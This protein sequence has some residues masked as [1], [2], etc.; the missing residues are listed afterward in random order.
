MKEK[1]SMVRKNVCVCVYQRPKLGWWKISLR[2]FGKDQFEL[3][4]Q[5]KRD[6]N[7]PGNI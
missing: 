1:Q 4:K 7:I 2:N 3:H 5:K 6:K